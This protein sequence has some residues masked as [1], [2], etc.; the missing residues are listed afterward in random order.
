[1]KKVKLIYNPRSGGGRVAAA[2]DEIIA[3]YQR[4]SYALV[5]F[6]LTFGADDRAM[7]ADLG[8]GYHHLLIAGGDGTINY[9][10]NLLKNNAIDIPVAVL[11]TGT[12]NDFAR[13]LNLPADIPTACRQILAGE[14]RSVDLGCA[15]GRY[16]VNVFSSGLF[17]DVSQKTPTLLKNT[18]GK[19]AY[20]MSGLGEVPNFRKMQIRCEADGESVYDGSALMFF[21]FN[22]KTAGNLK[23][24]YLSDID[25]GLL[26]V[27]IVKGDNIVETIR[28]VTAFLGHPQD[29]YP[30]DIVHVRSG[31]LHIASLHNETTDMDGQS[32][33]DF[34]LH[35]TCQPRALRV[36][37]PKTDVPKRRRVPHPGRK[38]KGE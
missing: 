33:P 35:I 38:R 4:R 2:L 29:H 16:F 8:E 21:V 10:V 17:T 11:P 24:G 15:N 30:K 22:G 6:R 13:L 12:A 20:Y 3:I 7:L 25:D 14:I 32:G 31:D 19:L 26:D 27:L 9:V 34:P 37:C 1:M 5:P 23:I 18:F 36:L 28:T